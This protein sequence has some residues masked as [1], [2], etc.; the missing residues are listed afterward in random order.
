MTIVGRKTAVVEGV[1][2]EDH[3]ELE[4]TSKTLVVVLNITNPV[5]GDDMA[6]L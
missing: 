3:P 1:V 2:S 4:L 5:A 6:P